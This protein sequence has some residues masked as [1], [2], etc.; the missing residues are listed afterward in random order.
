MYRDV[1]YQI[2]NYSGPLFL[3]MVCAIICMGSSALYHLL[4]D[5]SYQFQKKF[6]KID[7][8]GISVM[9][10]GCNTSPIYYSFFCD[11]MHCKTLFNSL[12]VWRNVHLG[13]MYI[14]C[15]ITLI[16]FLIPGFDK[17]KY[18]T[19]RGTSFVICGLCSIFPVIHAEFF[20]ELQYLH[21]FLTFPWLLG[22]LMYIFGAVLYMLKFPERLKPGY[23]DIV[24]LKSNF[25]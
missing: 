22:G 24:V 5:H 10:A 9:I 6:V 11:E 13:I 7:Y 4:K 12:L 18:R 14:S 8:A 16:M 17:A 21:D 3:F 1:R 23:F 19:F 15:S 20:T 2:I 25:K